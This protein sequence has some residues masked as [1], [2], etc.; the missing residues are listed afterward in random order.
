MRGRAGIRLRVFDSGGAKGLRH[1]VKGLR[2]RDACLEAR[3]PHVAPS[4][5]SNSA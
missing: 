4:A 3:N 5:A 2:N 1:E